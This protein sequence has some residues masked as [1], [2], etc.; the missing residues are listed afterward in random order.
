MKSKYRDFYKT[1]K[2]VKDCKNFIF[3][4]DWN[5]LIKIKNDDLLITCNN[6]GLDI[7]SECVSEWHSGKSCHEQQEYLYNKYAIGKD[8]QLWPKCGTFMEKAQEWNHLA[9]SRCMSSYWIYC[10]H[11]FSENHMNPLNSKAC[12]LLS[13][14]H[15]QKSILKTP[16]HSAKFTK[17]FFLLLLYCI[18]LPLIC[19]TIL[20]YITAKNCWYEMRNKRK[21][22][23]RWIE[24]FYALFA[25]L[26]GIL[27]V[28]I[29]IWSMARKAKTKRRKANYQ[30]NSKIVN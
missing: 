8:A 27:L 18:L 3:W 17:A 20:P 9:C 4:L 15:E 6:W 16:L 12:S 2:V 23:N 30:V 5:Q 22:K 11:K 19:A 7:W 24:W 25:T 1:L 26:F 14:P 29:T 28:P 21:G 13:N 10:R